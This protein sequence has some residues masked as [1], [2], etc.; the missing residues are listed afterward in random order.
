MVH[1]CRWDGSLNV[2]QVWASSNLVV[3][4]N[5]AV[6]GLDVRLIRGLRRFNSSRQDQIFAPNGVSAHRRGRA[7]DGSRAADGKGRQLHQIALLH[8]DVKQGNLLKGALVVQA[9]AL[10][11]PPSD[12]RLSRV[13]SPS[14]LPTDV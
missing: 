11:P 14:L 6:G 8:Y 2:S 13:R 1:E 3:Y 7:A 10:Y 5:P 9:G 4:P 12:E